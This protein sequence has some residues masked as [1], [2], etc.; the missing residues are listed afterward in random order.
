MAF[1]GGRKGA[2]PALGVPHTMSRR[3]GERMLVRSLLVGLVA[4]L[5]AAPAA[6][7]GAYAHYACTLHKGR[8]RGGTRIT[9]ARCRTGRRSD[10]M[11]E[12]V[13]GACWGTI[14]EQASSRSA[15]AERTV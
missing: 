5:I 15:A 4:L 14:R 13:G 2:A 7:A 10:S 1:V 9:R 8:G 11:T 6:G 12:V 3:L